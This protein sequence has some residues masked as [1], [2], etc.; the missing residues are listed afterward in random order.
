LRCHFQP[1]TMDD[2]EI[3]LLVLAAIAAL[4]FLTGFVLVLA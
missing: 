4:M 1:R 2:K 3:L